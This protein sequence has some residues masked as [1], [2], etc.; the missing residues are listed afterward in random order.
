MTFENPM[1]ESQTTPSS[2]KGKLDDA[3]SGQ[4]VSIYIESREN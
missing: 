4:N 1:S 2:N 3:I